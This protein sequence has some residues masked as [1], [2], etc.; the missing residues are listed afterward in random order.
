MPGNFT[1]DRVLSLQKHELIDHP[2]FFVQLYQ[3]HY[4]ERI[5]GTKLPKCS[6]NCVLTLFCTVLKLFFIGTLCCTSL[7]KCFDLV[8]GA[9]QLR[10]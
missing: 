10:A 1:Q 2:V 4:Q 9:E 3:C 5:L 8:F 7:L 6:C